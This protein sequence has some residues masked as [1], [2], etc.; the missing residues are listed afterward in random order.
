MFSVSISDGLS[1]DI[2]LG[3]NVSVLMSLRFRGMQRT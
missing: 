1:V 2:Y 3:K